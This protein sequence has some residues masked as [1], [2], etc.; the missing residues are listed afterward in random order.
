VCGEAHED[1]IADIFGG[2]AIG[3]RRAGPLRFVEHDEDVC[4][5]SDSNLTCAAT[6][7]DGMHA[8]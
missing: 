1:E 8:T 4:L 6:V 2:A 7:S 5:L 3:V